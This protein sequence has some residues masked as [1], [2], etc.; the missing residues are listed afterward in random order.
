LY[1]KYRDKGLRILAFPANDFGNQEPD[2]NAA[3][4]SFCKKNFD[5]SF[6]MFAKISVKGDKQAPLYRYLTEQPDEA[7]RGEIVWNFQKF[8]V[9]REGKVIARFHPK[10]APEA[11]ELVG[12]VEKAL[13]EVAKP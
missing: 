13:A 3:I 8:L 5:V 2:P 1:R 4:K 11:P 9:D 6:D 12:A 7:I 10:V